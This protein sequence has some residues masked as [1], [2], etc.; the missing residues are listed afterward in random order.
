MADSGN[1][2]IEAALDRLASRIEDLLQ[3]VTPSASPPFPSRSP[4][5]ANLHRLKL[6]VPRF[7]GTDPLGW[8]FKITQFFEYH[9]T[10]DHDRLT[11]AAFYME[12]R[13]LAWFQW[14]SSNDQFTSWPIFLQALQ[15]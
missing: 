13:A 3:H 7:D 10:P 1:D 9:G 4:V 14:M 11:I 6:D 12:G 5:P 8:I 2:R 15:S